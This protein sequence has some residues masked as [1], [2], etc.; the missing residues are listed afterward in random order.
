MANNIKL[1]SSSVKA[2]LPNK[3]NIKE[4]KKRIYL[5]RT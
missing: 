2:K 3:D 4:N 5:R 1:A